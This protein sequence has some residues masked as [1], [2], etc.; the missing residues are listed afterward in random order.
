MTSMLDVASVPNTGYSNPLSYNDVDQ[1][2]SYKISAI[3]SI[4]RVQS[5]V[6]TMFGIT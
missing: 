5:L 1:G 4:D 6:T 3:L 2:M